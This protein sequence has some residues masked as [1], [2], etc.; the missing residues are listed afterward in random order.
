L[1]T[2]D[3]PGLANPVTVEMERAKE[4]MSALPTSPHAIAAMAWRR[5]AARQ[6]ALVLPISP[7]YS[8]R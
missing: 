4:T 7:P 5:I 2:V 1:L 6:A 8:S 3:G